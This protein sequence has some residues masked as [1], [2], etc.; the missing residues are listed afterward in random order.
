[1]STP[2]RLCERML[3]GDVRLEPLVEGH[4]AT[5][6]EACA[7]DREIW[8]I[9][10]RDFGPEGFDAEFDT[11]L[12][13]DWQAFAAFHGERLVGMSSYIGID[14]DEGVLE[15]GCTYFH[16]DVRGTTFN[17]TVKDLMI[18]HAREC[19]FTN[20]LFRI[21][22]RNKRSQAAVRKLGAS[23]VDFIRADRVTWTGHVRDTVVFAL[24][25]DDWNG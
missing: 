22:D 3:S 11:L 23:Q 10:Y 20:I 2:A 25:A 17:R 7:A 4:R 14:P 12:A 1:M 16:P 8:E 24:N 6:K 21:D 5:L 13:N 18:R 9:Y 19:G 15:I